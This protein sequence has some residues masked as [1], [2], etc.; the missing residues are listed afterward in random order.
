[1]R[2]QGISPGDIVQSDVRGQRFYAVV[3]SREGSELQIEPLDSRITFRHVTARQ[4]V[5]HYRKAKGSA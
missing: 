4:I 2:T 3:T 5:G 1:M